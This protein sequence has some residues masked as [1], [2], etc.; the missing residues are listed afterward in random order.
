[1]CFFLSFYTLF[2]DDGY[3]AIDVKLLKKEGE[4][5]KREDIKMTAEPRGVVT[6]GLFFYIDGG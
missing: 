4:E 2:R 6:T 1:M 5:A 3:Y